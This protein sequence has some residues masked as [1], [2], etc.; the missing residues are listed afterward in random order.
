MAACVDALNLNLHPKISR[1]PG[2]CSI[3]ANIVD[4]CRFCECRGA[5]QIVN[6]NTCNLRKTRRM[7][8]VEWVFGNPGAIW[9]ISGLAIGLISVRTILN[10]STRSSQSLVSDFVPVKVPISR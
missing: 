2:Y 9:M 6:I 10:G 4:Y 7:T 5:S 3:F 1:F 8:M